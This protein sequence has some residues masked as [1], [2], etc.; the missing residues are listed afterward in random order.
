LQTPEIRTKAPDPALGN[1]ALMLGY[2]AGFVPLQST[3]K[4]CA[5]NLT[6]QNN[7]ARNPVIRNRTVLAKG[8]GLVFISDSF[9]ILDLRLANP[10]ITGSGAF[11]SAVCR[12]VV[13]SKRTPTPR[14]SDNGRHGRKA[15]HC[16]DLSPAA[17]K[18][19]AKIGAQ[20]IR[21]KWRPSLLWSNDAPISGK[22]K[23]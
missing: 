22:L 10:R 13:D 1:A 5:G 17:A 11:A 9:L 8:L 14:A 15:S 2:A 19:L 21:F 3:I 7:K 18:W 16:R 12:S 6:G 20:F 23:I 4:N